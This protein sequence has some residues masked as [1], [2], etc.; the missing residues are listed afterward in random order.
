MTGWKAPVRR[1]G[2]G[3]YCDSGR[4][5]LVRTDFRAL[6]DG[7][8][9]LSDGFRALLNCFRAFLMTSSTD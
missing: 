9:A 5:L 6:S 4:E 3:M 2:G 7:S 8:T 1:V